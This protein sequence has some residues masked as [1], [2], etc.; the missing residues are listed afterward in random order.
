M[1]TTHCTY[2]GEE[3]NH[4]KDDKHQATIDHV[5]IGCNIDNN[6]VACCRSCNASKGSKHV[7]DFYKTSDKFTYERWIVFVRNFAR[8]I[9]SK[10]PT[11]SEVLA[12]AKGF[13]DEAE[14]LAKNKSDTA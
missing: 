3:M 1:N 4:V 14:E 10:E 9:L 7:Y 11:S 12:F 8:G 13:K 2:C 6:V 5:F